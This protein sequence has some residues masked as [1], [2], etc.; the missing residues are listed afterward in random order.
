MKG[1]E[2]VV[3]IS[4]SG[5]SGS[6]WLG[7][8][9]DA[10]PNV[11]Y[12]HEP[13][14]TNVF[15]WFKNIPSR[16]N[17]NQNEEALIPQFSKALEDSFWH[18]HKHFIAPPFFT[19]D[20]VDTTAW[21]LMRFFLRVCNKTVG[22]KPLVP[23]PDAFFKAPM[24]E[25]HFVVK[26]VTSNFRLEWIIQNFPQIQNICIIRHPGGYIQSFLSGAKKGKISGFGSKQRL[27]K[28]V[29]PFLCEQHTIFADAYNN[30]SEFERELIYWVV[31]NETPF[32]RIPDA[33]KKIKVVVYEDL[34]TDPLNVMKEIYSYCDIP[35]SE[36]VQNFIQ[37]S[38]STHQDGYYDVCKD[39]TV[40][41]NKWKTSLDK[42]QLKLIDKYLNGSFLSKYWKE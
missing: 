39:P 4:G 26:T 5:R 23:I 19:K 31:S 7:K 16:I 37:T 35:F 13:D 12:R 10:S 36:S 18:Q 8:L 15:P 27:D 9:F 38:T 32:L 11:H 24:N 29:L 1:I 14:N 20:F 42:E 3:L 2:N 28:A 33:E 6:S 25:I 40:T 17:T 30:G 22:W 34:C 21:Q 41:A